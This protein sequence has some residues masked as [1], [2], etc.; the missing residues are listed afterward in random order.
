MNSSNKAQQHLVLHRMSGA[1][2]GLVQERYDFQT[3][4][5]SS[6][7]EAEKHAGNTST[8]L[9][10]LWTDRKLSELTGFAISTFR[11]QRYLRRQGKPHWFDVDPIR[12]SRAPRY[13]YEDIVAWYQRFTG[14]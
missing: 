7:S 10:P 12:G 1:V 13:R 4:L 9:Q 6:T 11:G 14:E 3:T 2:E 8:T 5:P